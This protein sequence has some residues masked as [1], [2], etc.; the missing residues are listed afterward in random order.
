M[1]GLVQI[2]PWGSHQS[3]SSYRGGSPRYGCVQHWPASGAS[4]RDMLCLNRIT[5]LIRVSDEQKSEREE[6]NDESGERHCR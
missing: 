6:L 3:S 4:G 5:D 2:P 1:L